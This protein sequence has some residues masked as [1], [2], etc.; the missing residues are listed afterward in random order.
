M[1]CDA[2]LVMYQGI[3]QYEQVAVKTVTLKVRIVVLDQLKNFL[4][5][6]TLFNYL[7]LFHFQII[8][9]MNQGAV[10]L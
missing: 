4:S 2:L 6:P 7:V 10:S 9:D 3:A 1:F 5:R 8:Q